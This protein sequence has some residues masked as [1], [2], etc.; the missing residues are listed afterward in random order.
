MMVLVLTLSGDSL[1]RV[2]LFSAR[3]EI[4]LT[5]RA[6]EPLEVWPPP[7]CFRP[8]QPS[9]EMHEPVCCAPVPDPFDGRAVYYI[10][11][12]QGGGVFI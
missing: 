2:V 7:Q 1:G 12:L 3:V 9:A 6:K 11:Y 10:A 4:S 8:T 5:V